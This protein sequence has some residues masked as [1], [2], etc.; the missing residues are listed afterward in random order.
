MINPAKSL[1]GLQCSPVPGKQ[2]QQIIK[3]QIIYVACHVKTQ[4]LLKVL[5]YEGQDLARSL[6]H[7]VKVQDL[8]CR[9]INL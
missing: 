2:R 3:E 7:S 6:I 9:C 8:G 1:F 4:L 5:C